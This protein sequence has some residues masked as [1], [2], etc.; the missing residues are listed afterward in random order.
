MKI[1]AGLWASVLLCT[2]ASA[3]ELDLSFNSDAVRA[4][5]IHDFANRDV[6]SDVG[7]LS[8]SDKQWSEKVENSPNL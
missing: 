6:Q 2:V 8:N 5:Y 4:F 7:F 1:A 3:G